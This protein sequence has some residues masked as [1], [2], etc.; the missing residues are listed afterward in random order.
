MPGFISCCCEAGE[1]ATICRSTCCFFTRATIGDW[2]H[3]WYECLYDDASCNTH[4]PINTDDPTTYQHVRA[5]VN[6]GAAVPGSDMEKWNGAAVSGGGN[7]CATW[8][9]RSTYSLK[10]YQDLPPSGSAC[11]TIELFR[12][13]TVYLFVSWSRSGYWEYGS[14]DTATIPA[15]QERDPNYV[16]WG[17]AN[18]GI[19]DNR[20]YTAA[21]DRVTSCCGGPATSGPYRSA[22][23][24]E[25][26][27]TYARYTIESV[28]GA[29]SN[30]ACCRC[31]GGTDCRATSNATQATCQD[32]SGG[33]S[34]VN[35]CGDGT[36][37]TTD[38]N[39]NC[40]P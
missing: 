14:Q 4:Q 24:Q 34:E 25:D 11:P 36:G 19:Y 12:D 3:D 29:V 39:N 33:A 7:H 6:D 38:Q 18:W 5:L 28:L 35:Y 32:G 21:G 2:S 1:C 27:N 26:A 30:N 22:C 31:T 13:Q 8:V 23:V 37:G 17:N 16:G 15:S 20:F 10:T 40:L 9:S